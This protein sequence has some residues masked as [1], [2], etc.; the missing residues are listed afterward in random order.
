MS[1]GTPYLCFSF[2][3]RVSVF[4]VLANVDAPQKKAVMMS[5]EPVVLERLKTLPADTQQKV[6]DSVEFLRQE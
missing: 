3:A 2:R 6:L 1:L 4:A 5:I